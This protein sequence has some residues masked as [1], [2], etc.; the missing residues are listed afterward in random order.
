M[1]WTSEDFPLVGELIA[2]DAPQGALV[3]LQD[4]EGRLA[5]QLRDD[6]EGVLWRGC[7]SFFGGGVE[8]GETLAEAAVREL[9]EETG[10]AVEA[11]ALRPYLRVQST[12]NRRA[13]LHCFHL[14]ADVT[15]A[16]VR[17]GEGAGFG[18]FTPAQ[19]AG[20]DF[21]PPM[22]PVLGRFLAE[23]AAGSDGKAG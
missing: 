17:V 14:R 11:T 6:W 12:A 10:L 1:T 16:Q 2:T 3:I 7:W 8:P 21:V 15:P 22:R 20:L 5:L 9:L 19:A 18:F 23:C 13:M 4:R